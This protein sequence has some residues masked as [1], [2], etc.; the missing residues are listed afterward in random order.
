MTPADIAYAEGC[1]DGRAEIIA[2]IKDAIACLDMAVFTL[3]NAEQ[4]ES[5]KAVRHV[6][7]RFRAVVAGAI[8]VGR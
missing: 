6:V 2:E 7:T 8:S 3:E 1:R 5:A 4:N